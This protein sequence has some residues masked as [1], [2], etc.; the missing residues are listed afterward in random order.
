M[1]RAIV[2]R[3]GFVPGLVPTKEEVRSIAT[4]T[5]LVYGDAD[6]VGSREIWE[7]FVRSM[8]AAELEIV[9]AGGHVVWL[10]DPAR[11]GAAVSEFLSA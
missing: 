6:P 11:V 2:S 10:D 4:P 9:P 5:L 7:R 3:D 8:P 1:V